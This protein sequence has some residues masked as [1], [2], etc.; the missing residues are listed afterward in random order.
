L[1][2]A[3]FLATDFIEIQGDVI[4]VGKEQVCILFKKCFGIEGGERNKK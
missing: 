2:S 3:L 1:L 4:A